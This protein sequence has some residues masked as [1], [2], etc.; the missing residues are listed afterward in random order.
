MATN[1]VPALVVRLAVT[2]LLL[3]FA[4]CGR[5]PTQSLL[6][7]HTSP[8]AL[9]RAVVEAVARKEEGVLRG[10]AL[11]EQEFRTRVWPDL[12]ASRPERNLPF[13][14]V[15]G[16]LRQ[17][18]DLGLRSMLT[19]HGGVR[20]ELV[21]VRFGEEAT[22]Y[23]SYIVHREAVFAVRTPSGAATELRLCGSFLQKDGV[24]KVFSYNID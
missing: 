17:K 12:P 7:A 13:S 14:Y 3:P 8:D 10:M 5:S 2:L 22:R 16:D 23:P 9:A 6:N 15:W 18:S 11:S 24:W 21:G 4:G 19:K 20:Y 1:R